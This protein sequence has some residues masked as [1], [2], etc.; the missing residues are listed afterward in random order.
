M[1]CHAT[2]GRL[3][4]PGGWNRISLLVTDLT[5]EVAAL[6]AAGLHFH[7]DIVTGVGCPLVAR[8]LLTTAAFRRRRRR[9]SMTESA[10]SKTPA[11]TNCLGCHQRETKI[12]PRIA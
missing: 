4:E 8:G 10:A 7:N 11:R 12:E 3:P 6:R 1:P 2:H 9:V 5:S